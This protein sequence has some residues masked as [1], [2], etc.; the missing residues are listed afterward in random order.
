MFGAGAHLDAAIHLV[1]G[2]L[3]EAAQAGRPSRGVEQDEA[4]VDVGGDESAGLV[5]RAVHVGLGREMHD[6]LGVAHERSGNR[7][8]RHVPLDEPVP[9]VVHGV[10]QILHASGVGQLVE[11]GD[12]PV[13]MRREGV[14]HEVAADEAGTASDQHLDHRLAVYHRIPT[15]ELS[16]SMKR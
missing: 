8:V 5:Q 15:S 6:D 2:N 10:T 9:R 4:T 1:C 14:Q 7:R 16:P 3:H 11:R 12:P 13:G